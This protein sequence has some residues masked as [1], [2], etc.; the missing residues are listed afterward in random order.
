[1]NLPSSLGG[2]SVCHRGIFKDKIALPGITVIIEIV[3]SEDRWIRHLG[4]D[5]VEEYRFRNAASKPTVPIIFEDEVCMRAILRLSGISHFQPCKKGG[6]R[7]KCLTNLYVSYGVLRQM[8]V[9]LESLCQPLWCNL[10]CTRDQ[11]VV[12]L[13]VDWS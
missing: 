4:D 5:F 12:C 2:V 9:L 3:A 7:F 10:L 11:L 1:M 13:F 6:G 8:P